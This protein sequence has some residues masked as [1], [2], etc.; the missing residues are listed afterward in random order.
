MKEIRFAI[1]LLILAALG[2]G[3]WILVRHPEWV[4]SAADDDED[5]A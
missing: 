1:G 2:L 3:G 4:K 5:A